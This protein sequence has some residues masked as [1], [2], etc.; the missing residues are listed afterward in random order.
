MKIYL[1]FYEMKR[2]PK[3]IIINSTM[4]SSTRC[5]QRH[6]G[7]HKVNRESMF[8]SSMLYEKLRSE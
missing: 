5:G 4:R 8:D 2:K 6:G 3:Q 1:K 7:H